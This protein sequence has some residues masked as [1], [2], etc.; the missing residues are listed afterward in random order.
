M[1]LLHLH[2]LWTHHKQNPVNLEQA[3]LHHTASD[4]G[5]YQPSS[6][7]RCLL[8]GV[9]IRIVRLVSFGPPEAELGSCDPPV[10]IFNVFTLGLKVVCGVIRAGH[11]YLGRKQKKAEDNKTK[12]FFFPFRK[13]HYL[14][15]LSI[16]VGYQQVPD[17]H[18]SRVEMKPRPWNVISKDNEVDLDLKCY[19]LL[20]D[21]LQKLQRWLHFPLRVAGFCRGAHRGDV[22]AVCRHVVG[23][24]HHRYVDVCIEE[25]LE[26]KFHRVNMVTCAE[27]KTW[28]PVGLRMRDDDLTGFGLVGVFNWVI[29]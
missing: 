2:L 10:H 5:D 22:N 20:H 23:T 15:P 18:E 1:R 29:Q 25:G 21:G 24:R 13:R 6:C 28:F 7:S 14:T 8:S 3:G 26:V 16:I 27:I 19:R 4:V 12:L 17:W 9:L 11:K